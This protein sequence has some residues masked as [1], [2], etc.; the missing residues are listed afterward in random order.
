MPIKKGN[1]TIGAIYKGTTQIAKVY[2][3]TTLLFENAVWLDYYFSNLYHDL[4]PVT[5]P[6]NL[7]DEELEIG[8]LDSTD[9]STFVNANNLRSVNYT[10]VSPSTTYTLSVSN[11]TNSTGIFVYGYDSSKTFISSVTSTTITSPVTFTTP[12]NCEY[13]KLRILNGSAYS[14]VPE[15]P[16]EINIQLYAKSCSVKNKAK[17]S[18]IYGNGVVENQL[19]NYTIGAVAT[20]TVNGITF[21]NNN[22][23]SFTVSGTASANAYIQFLNVPA[24]TNH[25]YLI[26]GCPRGGSSSTYCFRDYNVSS[27]TDTGSGAISQTNMT[28]QRVFGIYVFSGTAITTPIVFK[29]VII[30]LTIMFGTG[31]EPTAL[32]DNRIQALLNRGYI[33]YNAGTYK[34]T[35]I[36]EFS[37]DPYNLFDGELEGNGINTT[38]GAKEVGANAFRSK[39]YTTIVGGQSYKIEFDATPLGSGYGILI[40][41]YDEYFNYLGNDFSYQ[42]NNV[43]FSPDNKVKYILFHFY[44]GDSGWASN[45]PTGLNICIHRTGT[46]TGY[47]PHQTFT[48]I[49][50]KYQGNGALNA[51]DTMEITKDNVVFVKNIGSYTFT[52]S[53]S[54][55]TWTSDR[56]YT[57]VI[58]GSVKIPTSTGVINN[59]NFGNYLSVKQ[60]D[61]VNYDKTFAIGESNGNLIIRDTTISNVATSVTGWTIHYELAIPQTI[62]IPRKYMG[63]VDLGSLS[64][65]HVTGSYSRFT[66]DVSGIKTVSQGTDVANIFCYQFITDSVSHIYAHTVNGSIGVHNTF[67]QIWIYDSSKESMTVD[68]FKTAMQ[69]VYL[70][71][72]TSAETTDIADTLD[73]E[74]GGTI[75][76]DSEV[77][78]NVDMKIK[79][80]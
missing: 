74:A 20:Q 26:Y 27:A 77:L 52:G 11:F 79:C 15:Y 59:A 29:P 32:T 48:P 44:K 8:G 34:G 58:A 13:I 65:V 60:Y 70:F 51:H 22:D 62:T 72:E 76:T 63:M 67:Q 12:N 68:Q 46:R 24:N 64:W 71:Y 31:N 10:K 7:F 56:Y 14:S 33:P 75:T 25:K 43:S 39:N 5:I 6:K 2:K 61:L 42:N 1:T 40:H 28:Y 21:T 37:S 38:T 16:S 49:A 55:T 54:W 57:N 73:I 17:V 19:A 53:E 80:K 23:G 9:G 47:A 36:S 30:D 50:F 45:V 3:G 4:V 66:A 78:P 35:D 41:K 69:G 18:K